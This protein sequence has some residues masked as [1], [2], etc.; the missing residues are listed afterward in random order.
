MTTPEVPEEFQE[1]PNT[2]FSVMS[3]IRNSG[4]N[5]DEMDTAADLV[6]TG[7]YSKTVDKNS[8]SRARRQLQQGMQYNFGNYG[9]EFD[10][11]EWRAEGGG[12]GTPPGP[13][14]MTYKE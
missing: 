4:A 2:F 13:L 11:S 10:W 5:N 3:S 7:W 1:K 8:R 14:E 6:H 12:R 9:W